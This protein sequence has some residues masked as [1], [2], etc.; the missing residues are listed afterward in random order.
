MLLNFIDEKDLKP[1]KEA[2]QEIDLDSS[3]TI[4]LDECLFKAR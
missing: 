2:F 4:T 1:N 3:G